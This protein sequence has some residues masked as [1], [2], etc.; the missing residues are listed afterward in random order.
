MTLPPFKETTTN[1]AHLFQRVPPLHVEQNAYSFRNH[2]QYAAQSHEEIMLA[3]APSP[4][5]YVLRA[6]T[7][8]TFA[9]RKIE[10]KKNTPDSFLFHKGGN[11]LPHTPHPPVIHPRVRHRT[12]HLH[13][14]AYCGRQHLAILR[15]VIAS[16]RPLRA[17]VHAVACTDTF[18]ET[19]AATAAV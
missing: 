6:T 17:C 10:R 9:S 3:Q 5:H 16:P 13:I 19:R 1:H 8:T 4:T 2:S 14:Y 11:I 7:L 18:R 15:R 12:N